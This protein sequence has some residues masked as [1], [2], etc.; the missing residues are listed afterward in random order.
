MIGRKIWP[1][2]LAGSLFCGTAFA[3]N[4]IKDIQAASQ[5]TAAKKPDSLKEGWNVG[6][7]L[8]LAFAQGTNSNWAAGGQDFSMSLNTADNLWAIYKKRRTSWDNTLQVNYGFTQTTIQGFEKSSDLFDFLSRYGYQ[9]D[10][11]HWYISAMFDLRSQFSNGYNYYKNVAGKDSNQLISQF[12]APAYILLSPGVMYKP[13]DYF[14]VFLSPASA[15]WVVCTNKLLAPGFGIDT[16]KTVIFQLGA[17]ASVLFNK[18][19]FKN[20][21]YQARL[22]LF[23]NYLKN[24]GDIDVYSTNQLVMKI[25]KIMSAT[26]SLNIIYDDN[27]RRADGSLWGTQLQSILGL[28]LAVKL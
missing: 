3:Q 9:L 26:Y 24:F 7:I 22:D 28:G 8:T 12:F 20:V 17:F 2:I 15:R 6:G 5:E 13:V 1:G 25:N 14:S 10:S 4:S 18:A 11:G 19:I 21:A 27:A 23:T 16:G